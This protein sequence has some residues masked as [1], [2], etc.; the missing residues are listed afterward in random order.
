MKHEG[1]GTLEYKALTY[2]GK[3]DVCGRS[4]S[5]EMCF[6]FHVVH[7][8]AGSYFGGQVERAVSA[9]K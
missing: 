8:H 1:Q 2:A 5:K 3:V 6:F 4:H 9:A 7:I